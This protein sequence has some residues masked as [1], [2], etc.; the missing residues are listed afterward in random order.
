MLTELGFSV[1]EAANGW[2]AVEACRENPGGIDLV[3]TDIG[4]PVMDG[5]AACQ[6]LK[7]LRPGLPIV[8]TSG[9]GDA[10]VTERIEE[11]DI[12]GLLNKPYGFDELRDTLKRVVQKTF[13]R[14]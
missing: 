14:C 3:V 9:F 1:I 4:M 11:G 6:K 12:A 7:E 2:E 5:Y 10:V 13:H 8:I